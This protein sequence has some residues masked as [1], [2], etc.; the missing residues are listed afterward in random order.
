M[1]NLVLACTSAIGLTLPRSKVALS[2]VSSNV[3]SG[4]ND[5]NTDWKPN[6]TPLL[7]FSSFAA[8]ALIA[9]FHQ[10][11]RWF[12]SSLSFSRAP[13][14]SILHACKIMPNTFSTDQTWQ[15]TRWVHPGECGA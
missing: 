12:T 1:T 15:Q 13:S 6:G 4:T 7:S 9:R 8:L 2:V 11:S 5:F 3:R 14:P 10:P